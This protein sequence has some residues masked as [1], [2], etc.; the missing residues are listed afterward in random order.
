M[1]YYLGIDFGG[2]EIKIG[3]IDENGSIVTKDKYTTDTTKS[4]AEI[5][6]HIA[7]CAQE[8]IGKSGI[9]KSAIKGAGI[10]SPGLLDPEKGLLKVVTNVPQLNGIN[11]AEGIGRHLGFPAFLDNDVNAMTLGE[12]FFGAGKGF[13]HVI[14]LTLG[15]GVGGGIILDGKLYRGTSFTAGEIGHLSIDSNGLYCPCGN[16]GCLERYIGKD[17]IVTRFKAYQGKGIETGI[18]D[19]LDNGEITPKAIAMA[20][21]NGDKLSVEVLTETGKILGIALA[22]LTNVLNPEIFVIGGGIANAGDLI[23]EPARHEL[24]K[25][26]YTIPAQAVKVV[27]AA[28]KNDAGIVGSASIAVAKLVR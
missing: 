17:G 11:F 15:T 27:P 26:A 24:I 2:T 20:A 21:A 3:I 9:P 13:K 18:N 6:A 16:Y 14:G 22:S 19:Y 12:F 28:L 7:D 25:R 1:N 10:G 23:L 4:G 8:L 5:V